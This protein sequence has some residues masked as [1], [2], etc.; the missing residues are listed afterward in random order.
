LYARKLDIT[1]HGKPDM[2]VREATT[3]QQRRPEAAATPKRV[4]PMAYAAVFTAVPILFLPFLFFV[5]LTCGFLALRDISRRPEYV[6]TGRAIFGIAWGVIGL[7]LTVLVIIVM[8][9]GR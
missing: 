9:G 1:A 3:T 2:S 4:A 8:T 5:P 6:G 7:F